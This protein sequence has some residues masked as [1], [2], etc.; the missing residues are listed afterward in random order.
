M[1]EHDHEHDHGGGPEW[2]TCEHSI[3]LL[4]DY[5]EG[6]LPPEEMKALDRHFKACP[7]CIDFLRKYRTTPSLC[8]KALESDV[9]PEM[10]SRLT[11]F[12]TDK[13]KKT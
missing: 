10:A 6:A 9:P 7:P 3:E 1:S 4:L 12:L 13:I 5:L 11:N 2:V 8:R